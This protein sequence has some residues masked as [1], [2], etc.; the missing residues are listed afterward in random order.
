MHIILC[1]EEFQPENTA[2]VMKA[3]GFQ[4]FLTQTGMV[5]DLKN[6]CLAAQSGDLSAAF[7]EEEIECCAPYRGK[8]LCN[9]CAGSIFEVDPDLISL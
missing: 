9:T 7:C 6:K 4:L 3:N 1:A 8:L 5:F 2:E